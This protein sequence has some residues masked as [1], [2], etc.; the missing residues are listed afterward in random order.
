MTVDFLVRESGIYPFRFL[1]YERG[2]Y[3]Y[4]ELASID[5]STGVRTLINDPNSENAIAAYR[6]II[7]ATLTLQSSSLVTGTFADEPSA[8]VDSTAKTVSIGVPAASRFF[9]LVGS[10]AVSIKSLK[11]EGGKVVLTYQ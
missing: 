1:W 5:L 7:T 2:G 3:G 6:E 10:S 11:I 9:R 4:A 8:V